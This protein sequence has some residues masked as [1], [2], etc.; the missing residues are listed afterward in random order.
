MKL[1][2]LPQMLAVFQVSSLQKI[3]LTIKPLFIGQTDDELS[4]TAPI[5][6]VPTDALQVDSDWRAFKIEGVLDFSLVGILAKL[7]SLLAQAKISIFAI[8][9]YNTDYILVKAASLQTAIDVLQTAG[10]EIQQ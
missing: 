7:A 8:S 4:I 5:E 1:T 6:N 9:T 2:V 3:D 10:Y